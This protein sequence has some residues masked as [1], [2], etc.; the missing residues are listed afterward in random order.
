MPGVVIVCSKP[1]CRMPATHTPVLEIPAEGYDWGTHDPIKIHTGATACL[2]HASR[3]FAEDPLP[4]PSKQAVRDTL[5][6]CGKAP[7]DFKRARCRAVP[8]DSVE[9]AEA[10]RILNNPTR[11]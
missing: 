5:A 3:W 6:A 11:Q 8:L 2:G 7:P 10:E 4:E 1:R 9:A